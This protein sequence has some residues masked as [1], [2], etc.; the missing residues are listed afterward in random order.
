MKK[1]HSI[2]AYA[3]IAP[4]MTFGL[5]TAYAQ[6]TATGSDSAQQQQQQRAQSQAQQ[7]AQSQQDR[8]M[9]AAERSQRDRMMGQR[10]DSGSNGEGTYLSS[11][12]RN[13]FRSDKVIGNE[14][15][16]KS[17]DE[18]IGDISDLLIDEDGQ[19]VAVIVEVGG[20]LGMGQKD[21][22]IAWDSVE[23]RSNDDGDGREF[24]V[25][26]TKNDLRN[27]PEYK[28]D[29][30]RNPRTTQSGAAQSGQHQTGSHHQ[31]ATE[32]GRR[33]DTA[34]RP[35]ATRMGQSSRTGEQ[36]SKAPANAFHTDSLRG[37][38]VHTRVGDEQ[39]GTINDFVVDENGQILAVIV[40]LGGM[41]GIGERDVAIAWDSLE[42]SQDSDG[43][44]R[45]TTSMTRDSL[46]DAPDYDRDATTSP[47]NAPR[48][49]SN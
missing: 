30:S 11:Q 15:K 19:I 42:K 10:S 45:F 2:T 21:V 3:L 40:G 20:F 28:E 14:L 41:L 8:S 46:R 31:G 38:E 23:H 35:G 47:R 7:R 48:N 44:T 9:S 43:D 29:Q 17:D 39:A 33:A 25:D 6:P 22:A 36:L 1:L 12:P 27:A 32:S 18:S 24:T 34:Q 26:T 37:K 4:A 5:G 49:S 16:S 13:S